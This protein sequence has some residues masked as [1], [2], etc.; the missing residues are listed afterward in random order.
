MR[1][2]NIFRPEIDNPQGEKIESMGKLPVVVKKRPKIMKNY[3][4]FE[5][6]C[7]RN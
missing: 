2:E 7:V 4:K 5:Q 1:L 6:I 3:E